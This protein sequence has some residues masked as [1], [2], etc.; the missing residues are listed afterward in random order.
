MKE[1]LV[2]VIL[3]L[4]KTL[5]VCVEEMEIDEVIDREKGNEKGRNGDVGE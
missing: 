3:L 4:E 1:E 5:V 2:V